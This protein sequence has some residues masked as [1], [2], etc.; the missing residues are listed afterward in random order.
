MFTLEQK[1]TRDGMIH[2]GAFC[3]PEKKGITALLWVHGLASSFYGNTPLLVALCKHCRTHGYALA[4]FNTRGHD[5]VTSAKKLDRRKKKGYRYVHA[6]A[7]YEDFCA[8]AY[9]IEASVSF[10]E[11]KGYTR[12]VLVGHSTGAN[13]VCYYAGSR[14]DRRVAGVI[15][16]GPVSDRLAPDLDQRKIK[17]DLVTMNKYIKEGQ[18]DELLSGYYYYPITP[19]RYVSLLMPGSVEDTFDYGEKE[20]KLRYFS[21]IKQPLL[22]HLGE[23]DEYLDRDP[24]E[25]I[26]IYRE[27]TRSCAFEGRVLVGALHSYNGMEEDAAR[28]FVD[29]M[30]RNL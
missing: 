18:G 19:K 30:N 16:A 17:Q 13:K 20:P 3:T 8:S 7:G 4:S 10:L 6:G 12:I 25:L 28:D 24:T 14:R 1:E 23:N 22:V 5:V 15:L 11:E 21:Q 26:R 27:H 29:W 2:Q 9:D